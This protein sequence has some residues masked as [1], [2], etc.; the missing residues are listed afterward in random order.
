MT[1]TQ[2][3]GPV[4]ATWVVARRMICHLR[5]RVG[6]GQGA[7]RVGFFRPQETLTL[8]LPPNAL[9]HDRLGR[10]IAHRPP[11]RRAATDRGTLAILLTTSIPPM[12]LPK[13]A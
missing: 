11:V 6:T 2:L 3:G 4:T 12:T 8:V 1:I 7:R 5:G 10:H 13:T 9:D